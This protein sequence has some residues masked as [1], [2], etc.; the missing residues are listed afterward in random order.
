V[1]ANVDGDIVVGAIV[2]ASVVGETEVAGGLVVVCEVV[3]FEQAMSA[4]TYKTA[5][6]KAVI[7]FMCIS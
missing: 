7:F 2:G 1:G 5:T 6:K 3:M 4:P